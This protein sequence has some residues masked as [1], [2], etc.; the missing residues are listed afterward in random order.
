[1]LSSFEDVR[2]F[3][4]LIANDLEEEENYN[5]AIRNTFNVGKHPTQPTQIA[6]IV[7]TILNR[8]NLGFIADKYFQEIVSIP[9]NDFNHLSK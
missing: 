5:Q 1:M 2:H 8:K 6:L 9:S 4:N 3:A 7:F